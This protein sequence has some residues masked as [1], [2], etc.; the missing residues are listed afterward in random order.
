MLRTP[1]NNYFLVRT[2]DIYRKSAIK[3]EGNFRIGDTSPKKTAEYS[4]ETFV[5]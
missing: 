5:Y 1:E 3:C 2:K 4:A